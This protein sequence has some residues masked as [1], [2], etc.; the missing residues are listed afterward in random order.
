MGVGVA[1]QSKS[2]LQPRL[3]RSGRQALVGSEALVWWDEEKKTWTGDDTPDFIASSR[4][5]TALRK[6]PGAGKPSRAT[7]RFS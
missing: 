7:I 5:P 3:G 4:L 2:A 6:A 1:E